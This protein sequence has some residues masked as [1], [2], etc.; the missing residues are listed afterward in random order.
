MEKY[1]VCIN[2]YTHKNDVCLQVAIDYVLYR[3]NRAKKN[4]E[5]LNCYVIDNETGE[6]V[7]AKMHIPKGYI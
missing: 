7:F 6:I 5:M 4:K 1:W 3:I 2:G